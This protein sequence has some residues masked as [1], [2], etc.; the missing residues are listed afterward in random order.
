MA[1]PI[2]C[3]RVSPRVRPLPNPAFCLMFALMTTMPRLI[4]LVLLPSP[5]K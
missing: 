5:L 1:W 2:S 4:M 3:S